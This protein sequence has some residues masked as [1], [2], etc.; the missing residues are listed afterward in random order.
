MRQTPSA[1]EC[2]EAGKT[3]V[4]KGVIHGLMRGRFVGGERLTEIGAAEMFN[5]SRTPVREALLELSIMGIIHLRRNC[6]ALLLPFGTQQI[7]DLYSVRALL[8]VEATRLAATRI[9]METVERLHSEFTTLMNGSRKDDSWSRDRELH[10]TIALASGNLRLADEISR[11]GSIVQVIREAAGADSQTIHPISIAEHLRI[12][13]C[14]RDRNSKTA[15]KAMEDHLAQ[16]RTSA[17]EA[18]LRMREQK[19]GHTEEPHMLHVLNRP[20]TSAGA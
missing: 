14:L 8:E 4:I 1:S 17:R 2:S 12:L 10:S 6:G 13:E 3:S 9:P 16:A 18:L 19:S 7:E 15:A 20:K 11:Y 5:V